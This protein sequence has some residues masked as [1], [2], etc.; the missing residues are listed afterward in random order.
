MALNPASILPSYTDD[1]DEAGNND[2]SN[3]QL[4]DWTRGRA[5]RVCV[6]FGTFGIATRAPVHEPLEGS[7]AQRALDIAAVAA[8]SEPQAAA[9]DAALA[10]RDLVQ[11]GA[12]G[13]FGREEAEGCG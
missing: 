1:D 13:L 10:Q 3:S 2:L 7:R 9:T 6:M 5:S 11:G 8:G 12:F 4:Q